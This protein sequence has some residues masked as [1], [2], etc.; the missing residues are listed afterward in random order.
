RR[1]TYLSAEQR[2]HFVASSPSLL[3]LFFFSFLIPPDH[4]RAAS[5]VPI[6]A[7]VPSPSSILI[8]DFVSTSVS[9]SSW[10]IFPFDLFFLFSYYASFSADDDD[11]DVDDDDDDDDTND[12]L[13]PSSL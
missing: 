4:R 7:V 9:V 6:D 1:P 8:D 13:R 10:S 2:C 5:I 3:L 12:D 11:D